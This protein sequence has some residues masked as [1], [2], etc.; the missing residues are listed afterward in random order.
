MNALLLP[1]ELFAPYAMDLRQQVRHAPRRAAPRWLALGLSLLCLSGC[2]TGPKSDVARGTITQ[3]L[4]QA[5]EQRPASAPAQTPALPDSV[6][7]ALLPPLSQTPLLQAVAPEQRFDLSVTNAPAV[8]VFQAIASGSRYS[9]LLAPNVTG[10][11]TVGLKEV[12]VPE[13]LDVMR[14]LYG[15]EYRIEGTK[16]FVQQASLQT[17]MYQV[18]YPSS[19]RVGR[20]ETRVVSGSIQSNQQN[21]AGG[22]GGASSGGN[23]GTGSGGS[24]GGAEGS[25]VS[26][27]ND[28]EFW[29]ELEASLRAVVGTEDGRQVVLSQHSGV[30]VVRALPRE[31]REV[32]NY[33]RAAKLSVERQVMLEAKIVE[34]AL[35]DGYESGINW[36]H[37]SES[38]NHHWSAGVDPSRINVPGSIGRQYGIPTGS[39]STTV[40]ATTTPPT[41]IPTTLGQLVSS[42]LSNSVN[43]ALGLAFTT[44]SFTSLLA[45]LET[46]GS[47]HVL[48][49]PRVAAINNQ[50]AVLRVG[51]DDFFITNISTTTTSSGTS[52][53]TTPTITVQ[54]FF[55]GISLDV[56]PQIDDEGNVTLHIRPSVSVVSERSKVVNLGTLG[57]F[58]L[59][60]ASSN[61]NET[62]TVVRV[63]DGVTVAIGGLMQQTQSEDDARVPI[64]GDVPVVGNLFKRTNRSLQKRELVFLLRP[65]VIKGDGQWQSDL[66][67]AEQRIRGMD[68]TVRERLPL[69]SIGK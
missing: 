44:N 26:T 65:T 22:G 55:S 60:L 54:P 17:K 56:T 31:L 51:T 46:Q 1:P 47:V 14:E 66:A 9:M 16:V 48:S 25:Q 34:V 11:V 23:A 12:T 13:A 43:N 2:E 62:D 21:G 50:K 41:V 10:T 7:R 20:S 42:P 59:P 67:S 69:P 6:A 18:A 28:V 64:A 19:H 38:G 29:R 45:F 58:N 63:R 49:S 24:T 37:F 4:Q 30:I 32:D 53:V 8:Q 36:S 15:F 3:E 61:I 5:R 40:D 68:P 35:K 27:S 52:T 33:L 39:V 57:T